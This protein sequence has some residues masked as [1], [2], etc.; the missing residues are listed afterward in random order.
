MSHPPVDPKDFW[1]HKQKA[2]TIVRLPGDVHG[3]DLTIEDLDDCTVYILDWSAQITID[4]CNN[5]KFVIGPIDGPLFIRNCNNCS[6]TVACRQLRTRE[7]VDSDFYLYCAT[8]SPIIE[9]SSKR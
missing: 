7:C 3:L 8:K 4:Y 6:V 2:Q 1:I 5:T 9:S